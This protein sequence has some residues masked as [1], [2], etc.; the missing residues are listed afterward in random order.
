[1]RRRR[2]GNAG[3]PQRVAHGALNDLLAHLVPPRCSRPRITRQPGC[4]ED[5]LSP[6]FT[7]GFRILALEGQ[8]QVDPSPTGAQVLLVEEPDPFEVSLE[9]CFERKGQ[10]GDAILGSFPVA[11]DKLVSDEIQVFDPQSEAFVPSHAAATEQPDDQPDGSRR[12]GVQEPRDFLLIEHRA[13]GEAAAHHPK[14][15]S[16]CAWG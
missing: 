6:P 3:E 14:P 12:Q 2:L 5:L 15:V 7:I 1:M 16:G 13:S 9:G 4:G 10:H 11:N 8:G